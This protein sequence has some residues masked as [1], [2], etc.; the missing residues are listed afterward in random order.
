MPS[1]PPSMTVLTAGG[2]G[3]NSGVVGLL[4]SRNT[5][6]GI[7]FGTFPDV[8]RI[9]SLSPGTKCVGGRLEGYPVVVALAWGERLRVDQWVERL[10][11]G[12][13]WSER[14][15][16]GAQLAFGD[17]VLGA[18]WCDV[19]DL[20]EPV[21]VRCARCGHEVQC[22][23]A[24]DRE[25]RGQHR[26]AP[27]QPLAVLEPLIGRNIRRDGD[28]ALPVE[29]PS[30]SRRPGWPGSSRWHGRRADR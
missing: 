27:G 24:G 12:A 15:Q 25:R 13:A 11:R 1:C 18:V 21:G 29:E 19:G 3:V 6:P 9:C 5:V 7:E 22:D 26:R 16:R 17:D 10:G 2:S 20:R 30:S 4:G 8:I 14:S 28:R 23:W